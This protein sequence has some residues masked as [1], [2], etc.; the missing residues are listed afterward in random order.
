MM[1]IFKRIFDV[2]FS[3]AG[4]IL[5]SPLLLVVTF[6]ILMDDGAPVFYR[7]NRVGKNGVEFP[8]IKFRTM[9][10][11]AERQGLLTIGSRD[12]RITRTGYFLRKYK[13]DELP[14]LFNVLAGNM[15][16]V[17]PRPE[18][19][20]YVKL[21]TPLQ[22]KVLTVKPGITDWASIQYFNENEI[23]SKAE[24]PEKMYVDKIIPLKIQQNLQY[25][26][27]QSLWGDLSILFCTI[28]RII[29]R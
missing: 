2:G 29:S 12:P 21:Y 19:S 9:V 28:K 11:N 20:K 23:L 24:N 1:M 15:S 6:L 3:L 7:Q 8:L 22:L 13:L 14:Q 27:R 17:G 26:S 5:L 16:L 4:I 25:I 18:V 10:A